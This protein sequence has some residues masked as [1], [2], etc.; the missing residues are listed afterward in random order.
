VIRIKDEA[1]F[2]AVVKHQVQAQ[3]V[4]FGESLKALLKS[5]GFT[6]EFKMPFTAAEGRAFPEAGAGLEVGRFNCSLRPARITDG[7]VALASED[8]CMDL[9]CKQTRDEGQRSKMYHESLDEIVW[10]LLPLFKPFQRIGVAPCF[11]P[12]DEFG[13]FWG[14]GVADSLA[15]PKHQRCF[16][17]CTNKQ[18]SATAGVLRQVSRIE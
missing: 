9:G 11:K 1:I 14:H 17:V 6:H 12:A 13:E 16:S 2:R 8:E 4:N 5:F 3:G 18:F 15:L 7:L 10:L